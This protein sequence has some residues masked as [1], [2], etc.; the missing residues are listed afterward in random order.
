[1][2]NVDRPKNS[3]R[4]RAETIDKNDRRGGQRMRKTSIRFNCVGGPA[5]ASHLIA[6]KGRKK[7]FELERN[8]R[9]SGGEQLSNLNRSGHGERAWENG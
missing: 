6:V 5:N 7:G 1:M 8:A 3:R 2:K 4:V 9:L